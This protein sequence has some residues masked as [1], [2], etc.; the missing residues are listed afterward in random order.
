MKTVLRR[1]KLKGVIYGAQEN[2]KQWGCRDIGSYALVREPDNKSD[3][4]AIKVALFG[5]YFM[6]YVP[7]ELACWLAPQ[8]DSGKHFLALFVRRNEHPYKD[9]V[10]LTVDIVELTNEGANR[11]AANCEKPNDLATHS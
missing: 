3:P 8:I 2:I 9:I 7:R 10:G 11:L 5:K 6:G 1:V 4:N